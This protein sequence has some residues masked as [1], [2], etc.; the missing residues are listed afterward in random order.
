[1]ETALGALDY[2]FA[3]LPE[4]PLTV[5]ARAEMYLAA[6][7][8]DPV[9]LIHALNRVRGEQPNLWEALS[10]LG[11]LML[12]KSPLRNLRV[13]AALCED[14]WRVSGENPRAG[15]ALVEA[16]SALGKDRLAHALCER[17]AAGN[18]TEAEI[19]RVWL[20]AAAS[21]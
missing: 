2:M 6:G 9:D 4:D 5:V 14:A 10:A 1:M 20:E 16:W 17:L 15:L 13:G 21:E 8:D 3:E 18:S 11:R 12:A 19:A 7:N